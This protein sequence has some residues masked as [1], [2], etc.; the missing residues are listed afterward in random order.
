MKLYHVVSTY[1]L[2]NA[3]VHKLE[4]NE[5]ATLAISQWIIQKF[6]NYEQL[7]T[8]FENV[9]PCVVNYG[10]THTKEETETY[11]LDTLGDL[12]AYEEIYIWAPQ[13]SLGVYM[14]ENDLP[15]I[16]CEDAAGILS[17][18]EVLKEICRKTDA[19]AVEANQHLGVYSGEAAS[20]TKRFCN[21]KAQV[22]GF[23]V[24][25]DIIDFDVIAEMN[26]LPKEQ[27]DEII[28]FFSPIKSIPMEEDAVVLITQHFSNLKI[29][30]FEEQVLAYQQ[31]VD[32]FFEGKKLVIKPH[33]D[34]LMYYSKL[35]PEARI[36]REKF[37]SEFLPF[38]L[39]NQPHCMATFSSTAIYNLRGH[40]PQVFELDTRY[41]Q[42]F[43][44]THRY[45]AAIT[46]AKQL[47]LDIACVGANDLL[48]K[49]LCET[50]GSAAPAVLAGDWQ[51]K[52]CFYIVDDVTAQGDEG[53]NA[54][55]EHLLSLDD[56]SCV[57]FIN[58]KAD[59]CWYAYEHKSLWEHIVPV[60]L[61]KVAIREKDEDFCASL[62][63][64]I[65]Y[66]YSKSEELLNM[67]KKTEI[68][69]ELPH[70]GIRVETET[71][72]PEQEKIKMLEGILAATEKRL[73]HYIAK[74][75]E[76]E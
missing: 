53:R 24:T 59:Y 30:E 43:T 9:I 66:V 49:R 35:F 73:L 20:I 47:G 8:Y 16:F 4:S 60:V 23:E 39:E 11:L 41:E 22:E 7:N 19:A 27:R 55:R 28:A 74:E 26:K 45:Y 6:P 44:M 36:I 71:M 48:V 15:F 65:L 14:A 64:E 18:P 10:F 17:R 52:P 51:S 46:M 2:L 58:S 62:T 50:M 72:T 76:E 25:E 69:K 63:N 54:I 70:V 5:P 57:V 12:S 75:Q 40:Y 29:M 68:K 31:L 38:I 32:Y 61:K 1:Q 56:R 34:D 42:D 13:Y 37:P 21:A 33:P 3:V 67:T